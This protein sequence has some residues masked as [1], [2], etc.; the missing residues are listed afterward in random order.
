MSTSGLKHDDAK[1]L[2][3]LPDAPAA[4]GNEPVPARR[5]SAWGMFWFTIKAIEI[6]LRFIAILVG[7]GLVIG[8]WDGIRNYWDKWTRPTAA[9]VATGLVGSEEFYCPMHPNVTRDRLDPD[10]AVP[11]CPICGMP[12]S[13][14][15]KGASEALPAGVVS[16]VQLSPYRIQLAGVETADVTHRP[17]TQD[18][19]A[20]GYVAVDETKLSR[21]VVRAAGYVEKLYVNSS[22]A[23]VT[24][25]EPLAEIYSPELYTASQE[26]LINQR[27]QPV[28][29]GAA[30]R[31]R[32]E[33]LGVAPQE[34]DQMLKNGEAIPRLVI[35]SGHSGHVFQKSVV[36]GD[37]VEPGQVLFELADLSTVWVEGELYEQEAAALHQDQMV[38]A[39][40]DA[41][42]GRVF[43]GRITL[44]HPHVE[45]ATRTLR[46]RCEIAN[47]N[48]E[49]RPGMFATLQFKTP[50]KELEPF[51]TELIGE[52]SATAWARELAT[53][54]AA[55]SSTKPSNAMT[56]D[57]L[58]SLIAAQQFCPVTG[59]KLGSMGTPVQVTQAG[60]LVLLCCGSC[61]E[62]FN[63]RPDYY[64]TRMRKVTDDGVLAVPEQAVIDTGSEKVV[65]VER[66]P[67]VFEGVRVTL[68]P[69]SGN[70]YSVIDGLRAGDRVAAAG[71]FLVDAETRLNPAA[72]AE[73]FGASGGPAKDNAPPSTT[74]P[75]AK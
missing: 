12:L 53:E 30:A 57:N 69:R 56:K 29:F 26:L 37:R 64:L 50:I 15:K 52:N 55:G 22:F 59:Q 19:R 38:E 60:Q 74:A 75:N 39:T 32:L 4:A 27:D 51:R 5:T 18:V 20:P 36:E 3:A 17:L 9:S 13:T 23:E 42:P 2:P 7:I 73:Y 33:L 25:G 58:D 68:G 21:I 61:P 6:R 24:E 46:V 8:Y 54:L 45:T 72:S 66:E 49:L 65:Y 10:G 14:R 62:K 48:H 40:L 28:K 16:R 44:V 34:I 67:G 70:Y 71:A 35:R 11:K 47:P 31:K 1:T 63:A 41:Y 43:E